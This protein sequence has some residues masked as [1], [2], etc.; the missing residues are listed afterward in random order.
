MMMMMMII[1]IIIIIIVMGPPPW[2][3]DQSS[4]QQIQRPRV[5]SPTLADF[6]RSNGSGTGSTE[7]REDN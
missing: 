2:S 3:S 7:P 5:R 6:L 1:I 4:W